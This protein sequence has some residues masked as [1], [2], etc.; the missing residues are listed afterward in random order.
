M[1]DRL[2]KVSDEKFEAKGDD[3]PIGTRIQ[4]GKGKTTIKPK[5]YYKPTTAD[6]AIRGTKLIDIFPDADK[7]FASETSV[8][9]DVKG[10]GNYPGMT[11]AMKKMARDGT[12]VGNSLP[13]LANYINHPAVSEHKN[14]PEIIYLQ[15][16]L[17]NYKRV[18]GNYSKYEVKFYKLIREAIIDSYAEENAFDIHT[19]NPAVQSWKQYL[20]YEELADR[21]AAD[22]AAIA[23]Y[24][25]ILESYQQAVDEAIESG[26]EEG[27]TRNMEKL[28]KYEEEQK[29]VATYIDTREL[30]THKN[31]LDTITNQKIN[32]QTCPDYTNAKNITFSSA[33]VLRWLEKPGFS[34][35]TLRNF[36]DRVV[37]YSKKYENDLIVKE[38]TDKQGNTVV[39]ELT[40]IKISFLVYG[41]QVDEERYKGGLYKTLSLPALMFR[42]GDKGFKEFDEFV[43]ERVY[44]AYKDGDSYNFGFTENIVVEPVFRGFGVVAKDNTKLFFRGHNFVTLCNT[45][46]EETFLSLYIEKFLN[47]TKIDGSDNLCGFRAL[48][49]AGDRELTL[50][51]YQERELDVYENFV[52]YIRSKNLDVCIINKED[53]INNIC[54][55]APPRIS[56]DIE[57]RLIRTRHADR[58]MRY[59]YKID[60][61]Q[62]LVKPD[63]LETTSKATL[64]IYHNNHVDK[65]ESFKDL[66]ICID[67]KEIHAGI[68]DMP[69]PTPLITIEDRKTFQRSLASFCKK[70]SLAS[71]PQVTL[72]KKQCQVKTITKTITNNIC[73][74]VTHRELYL[75]FETTNSHIWMRSIPYSA[76]LLD[77]NKAQRQIIDDLDR[78]FKIK[79]DKKCKELLEKNPSRYDITTKQSF[80]QSLCNSFNIKILEGLL[81]ED[82]RAEL[83]EDIDK[84]FETIKPWTTFIYSEH[85][86]EHIYTY[87]KNHTIT[88]GNF[89]CYKIITF[90]GA[91]FDNHLLYDELERIDPECV[92]NPMW[93]GTR[94]LTFDIHINQRLIGGTNQRLVSTMWDL[95]KHVPGSLASICKSFNVVAL[96][97]TSFNHDDAQKAFDDGCLHTTF[98]DE[99]IK[100]LE[101]Y[102]LL[103]V[104]S[105]CVLVNRYSNAMDE[106]AGKATAFCDMQSHQKEQGHQRCI[107]IL[108]YKTIGS[109]IMDLLTGYWKAA[110]IKMPEWKISKDITK[111]QN[112][113]FSTEVIEG[114]NKRLLE[115]Y[116]AM[117]TSKQGGRCQMRGKPAHV[118]T[119]MKS[120]DICSMYPFVLLCYEAYYPCGDIIFVD[121]EQQIPDGKIGWLYCEVSNQPDIKIRADKTKDGNDWDVLNGTIGGVIG[122]VPGTIGDATNN[123][124]LCIDTIEIAQLRKYGATVKTF[125]GIYFTQKIE[126][127]KLFKPLLPFMDEKNKQDALP[128][129]ERNIAFRECCKLV[130]N[131]AGGKLIEGLHTDKIKEVS[132]EK[133]KKLVKEFGSENIFVVKSTISENGQEK[134]LVKYE[135]SSESLIKGTA[136]I[137]LGILVYTYSKQYMYDVCLSKVNFKYTDTDSCHATAAN[138]VEWEEWAKKTPIPVWDYIKEYHRKYKAN[139]D[140]LNIYNEHGKVFGSFENE[141]EDL[142]SVESYQLGKKL[143]LHIGR[144]YQ[145]Y[146]TLKNSP[147][148]KLLGNKLSDAKKMAYK[149]SSKG[150]SGNDVVINHCGDYNREKFTSNPIIPYKI[151]LDKKQIEFATVVFERS[152]MGT[153]NVVGRNKRININI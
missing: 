142:D 66:F 23:Q 21:P 116:H 78:Q 86:G 19:W 149:N 42:G 100:S 98:K 62:I 25:T 6:A 5:Y 92:S 131:S 125:D 99:H 39:Q 30:K 41:T 32:I 144:K 10:Y 127:Y 89:T 27:Y 46:G 65:I 55:L 119:P 33:G 72:C 132:I 93:V 117:Y 151:M 96:A 70:Q 58:K 51:E 153:I 88:G 17:D 16:K 112:S 103:D 57:D 75:D 15:A 139:Y 43:N 97:K 133:Y 114:H 68:S 138:L 118:K 67:T 18:S 64:L 137:Q 152:N 50:Q 9:P 53:I 22:A 122:T 134:L 12:T 13:Y 106:L 85:V 74:D 110:D 83:K 49:M 38:S 2:V 120:M 7:I 69:C 63:S 3:V 128:S 95:R 28:K 20:A 40:H 1:T 147:I 44:E 87:L 29:P 56:D 145:D 54:N 82:A 81:H 36:Y 71:Y 107:S 60:S 148:A 84:M 77:V 115:I 35:T 59:F 80:E 141:L 126:N 47:I 34:Q 121:N 73:P 140:V 79:F 124:R 31:V 26:D 113:R 123:Q 8:V 130:L 11:A 108:E 101:K 136:P 76:A 24:I 48:Q 37:L 14:Y 111:R 104:L 129:S 52:K 90:N 135:V 146:I 143:Y 94:L 150:V 91:N 109:F 102:N 4:F 105:L 61:S 45:D